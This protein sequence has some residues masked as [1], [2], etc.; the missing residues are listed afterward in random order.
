MQK[1]TFEL[2]HFSQ[3]LS[4]LILFKKILQSVVETRK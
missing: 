1:I 2:S 4:F 3:H